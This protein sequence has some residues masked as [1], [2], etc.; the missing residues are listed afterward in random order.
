MLFRLAVKLGRIGARCCPFRLRCGRCPDVQPLLQ[1][2]LIPQ[3]SLV[4]HSG[5]AEGGEHLLHKRN[6]LDVP[7]PHAQRIFPSKIQEGKG[8]S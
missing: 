2:R 3:P 6:D 1:R 8:F 5:H 4:Q 7:N